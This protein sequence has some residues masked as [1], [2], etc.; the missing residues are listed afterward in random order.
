[1]LGNGY[2]PKISL[3]KDNGVIT[4]LISGKGNRGKFGLGYKPTQADSTR[5]WARLH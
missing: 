3:G 1:M 4:S 2:E 5:N